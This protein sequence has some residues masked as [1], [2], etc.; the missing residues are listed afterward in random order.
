MTTLVFSTNECCICFE[1]IEA[2]NNCTTRCGHTFCLN[3]MIQSLKMNTTCPTCRTDLDERPDISSDSDIDTYMDDNGE[4]PERYRER[5]HDSEGMSVITQDENEYNDEDDE[6]DETTELDDY[7]NVD[8][9]DVELVVNEFVKHGYDLKD[10]ISIMLSNY[11]KTDPKY[12]PEYIISLEDNFDKLIVRLI[13]EK[14]ENRNMAYED[15]DS[16]RTI[17]LLRPECSP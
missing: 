1:P 17:N 2:N 8:V 9:V 12:T 4:Y 3:C 15:D 10:A 14:Q 13:K 11:S 6:D 5:I 7:E 16:A